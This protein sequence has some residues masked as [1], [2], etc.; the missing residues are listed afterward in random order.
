[1]GDML[2]IIFVI[3]FMV[4][5]IIFIFSRTRKQEPNSADDKNTPEIIE[6]RYGNYCKECGNT[7]EAKHTYCDNCGKQV[8]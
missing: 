2:K 1:M 7:I 3:A 5:D 6:N 8:R 4:V